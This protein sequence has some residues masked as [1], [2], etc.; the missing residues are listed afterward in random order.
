MRKF[1]LFALLLIGVVM[2]TAG[3]AGADEAVPTDT[4]LVI[5][6]PM[7]WALIGGQVLPFLVDLV[8]KTTAAAWLKSFILAA[9]AA[10]QSL[11]LVATQVDGTAVISRSAVVT[12]FYGW[13][14]AVVGYFGW[15]RKTLGPPVERAVGGVGIGPTTRGA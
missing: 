4:I 9:L 7:L 6:N 10:A 1:Y 8:T 5:S 12:F 13:I 15:Y 14:S 11:V 3:A 2:T